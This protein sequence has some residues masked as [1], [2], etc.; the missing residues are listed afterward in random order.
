MATGVAS[1][2]KTPHRPA[3]HPHPARR[4]A[5]HAH[6]GR[7]DGCHLLLHLLD[8]QPPHHPRGAHRH[9]RAPLHRRHQTP[10]PRNPNRNPRLPPPPPQIIPHQK[11]VIYPELALII[12]L[13]EDCRWL[14]ETIVPKG[15]PYIIYL[16]FY[17]ACNHIVLML[18]LF[19]LFYNL[20][21]CGVCELGSVCGKSTFS[22]TGIGKSTPISIAS[23]APNTGKYANVDLFA[24]EQAL[25]T[26]SLSL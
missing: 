4:D 20:L 2:G 19:L 1:G 23:P 17:I 15:L 7:R 11:V 13:F 5:L 9:R 24:A 12:Y 14:G 25:S 16:L 10:P 21:N 26:A 6:L 8:I 18:I 22:I 3:S